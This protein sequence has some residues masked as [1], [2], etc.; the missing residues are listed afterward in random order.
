MTKK[1]LNQIKEFAKKYYKKTDQYHDWRHVVSV[2]RNA[3]LLAK[4]FYEVNVSVLEA[5]CYLHDIGRVVKDDGH[6]YESV[7]LARPFLEEIRLEKEEVEMVCE[8]VYHHGRKDILKTDLLEAKLLFDADKLEI[9]SV[10]GFMRVCF[11][12][13]S[14]REMDMYEAVDFMW[15]Y[16]KDVRGNYLQTEKAKEIADGELVVVK[17]LVERFEDWSGG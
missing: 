4:D 11:F 5:S 9:V 1:Q 2:R 16:V 14:E 15:E 7:N 10:F 6:P 17:N 12:L 13:V 8:A 3:L